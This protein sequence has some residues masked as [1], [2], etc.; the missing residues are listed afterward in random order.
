MAARSAWKGYLKISLVT[1]PV[2]AFSTHAGGGGPI[3]LN[4]LHKDCNSR[5]KHEKK[6]PIHGP[7]T[8]SEIVSGYKLGD[9][10][11]VII[12]LEELDK[13]RTP[14]DKTINVQEFVAPDAIDPLFLAGRNHYLVPDGAIGQKPFGVVC[15]LLR[16][17]NCYAIATVVMKD[18]EELV[19][20]R[21]LDGLL[22]MSLLN[23]HSEV[24][25]TAPFQEDVV[26]SEATPG[27]IEMARLLFSSMTQETLDYAKYKDVYTEKLA[28]LI[29]IKVEGKQI[30][31]PPEQE[32]VKVINLMDALVKSLEKQQAKEMP[33]DVVASVVPMI[34]PPVPTPAQAPVES[35][36]AAPAAPSPATED[37]E[38][39]KPPRKVSP[40]A[41]KTDKRKKKS[42]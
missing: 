5:I 8:T 7:V 38:P 16:E 25:S 15:Q 12:D 36:V 20:L 27:E 31:A 11:Y 18:K 37:A 21:E 14:T 3:H 19:L 41:G 13:L 1:V 39:P 23:Y 6:C 32:E 26:R 4:Q 42:S 22:V 30:V 35:E 2:R 10:Q 40:R 33:A 17:R 24:S 34:A 9:D 28:K 29:D